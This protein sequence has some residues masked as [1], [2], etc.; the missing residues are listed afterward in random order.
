MQGDSNMLKPQTSSRR[1]FGKFIAAAAIPFALATGTSQAGAAP[2][3]IKLQ[4]AWQSGTEVYKIVERFA[5]DVSAASG[6]RVNMTLHPAGA[7]VAHTETLEAVGNGILG[8]QQTASVYFS[9]R[10]AA[11]GLL[12]DMV[13][14][15]ATPH[16]LTEW[17]YQRGGI[18]L[19][20]EL[21]AKHG[22]HYVG[23]ILYSIESVPVK[24]KVTNVAEMK[25]LKIRAPEGP[26]SELFRSLGAAPVNIPG[27]DV[28]AAL[29]RGV[30][31]ATD[32]GTLSM[33]VDLGYNKITKYQMYPGFHSMPEVGIGI[34]M[35]VWKKLPADVQKIIEMGVRNVNAEMIEKTH[36]S[37]MA[38]EAKIRQAGG[39][40]VNWNDEERL[41]V[42]SVARGIWEKAGKTNPIAKKIY[43]S[44]VAHLQEIGLLK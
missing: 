16:Q 42:R 25:G 17:F 26:V 19:A 29:E 3:E 10:D 30:I 37:D 34:N 43:E 28:Y 22:V 1:R 32:W 39:E 27:S 24:R 6:G 4:S 8:G 21:Y 41:K 38:A 13:A 18:Q 12:G 20:R 5:A 2:V 7:I 31:D 33:N 14:S 44:K 35:A 15:Y 11:F 9:G 36:L 23:P 40:L